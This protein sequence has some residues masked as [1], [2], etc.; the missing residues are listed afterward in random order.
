MEAQGARC[1]AFAGCLSSGC[2]QEPD[3]GAGKGHHAAHDLPGQQPTQVGRNALG[4]ACPPSRRASTNA[5]VLATCRWNDRLG[6]Y[7][8][9]FNGRVTCAS[10]KNFQ[11]V[12]ETDMD[13][14]VLQFG[15]V[16]Q[17]ALATAAQ[18]AACPAMWT[19]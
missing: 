7:C 15:K 16:C 1:W 12:A 14:V 8:L 9:N 3:K 2:E 5:H 6:A 4:C 17:P 18:S 10:V 13:R 19:S 11:L